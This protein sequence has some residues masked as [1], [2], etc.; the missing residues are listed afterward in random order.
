MSEFHNQAASTST[1]TLD[2][3]K[4]VKYSL[5]MV[6]G[7]DD[8]EQEFAYVSNL[9]Q[10]LARETIGYGTVCGLKVSI[11]MDERGPRVAVEPGVALTPRGQL[12]RVTPAQCAYINDW[13]DLHREEV[14]RQIGSPLASQL[15]L[16]V[17]LCY[18]G[19]P[20]DMVPIPGEPCRDETDATVDSRWQDD[21]ELKLSLTPPEQ[22]EEDA[23][24]YF[25]AWLS[26]IEITQEPTSF[27]SIQE[28][29]ESLRNAA[30]LIESSLGSPPDFPHGS[31]L[32]SSM[33][34]NSAEACDYLR[35]AFRLWV[36]ELRP[37][38]RGYD[39]YTV[40]EGDYLATIA[41]KFN[42]TDATL[43]ALNHVDESMLEA[44]M[45][46]KIPMLYCDGMPP[47]EECLLLAELDVPLLNGQ[48]DDMTNENIHEERRPYLVHLRMLQEWLL[49]GTRSMGS[50]ISP[51]DFVIPEKTFG[52]NESPG[53]LTD[54]YALAD[55]TH[56]T[57]ALPAI[58]VPPGPADTV[59]IE[60]Q[61]SQLP[62][63]GS[64]MEYS[65][66]DHSHGTPTLP[67]IPLPP[68]PADTVVTETQFSLLPNAGIAIEYSRADHTHGT[69]AS[70]G[71]PVTGDFVEHLGG[72]PQYFIIAAGVVRYK[73]PAHMP[74][75]NGL[76]VVGIPE[77]GEV[78]VTFDDYEPPKIDQDQYIVKVLPVYNI[79]IQNESKGMFALH[80][81]R[82][83]DVGFYLRCTDL[84]GN[85]T[86]QETLSRMEFMIEVSRYFA[87]VMQPRVVIE[88][89]AANRPPIDLNT[90][91]VA[92]LR[93]LPRIGPELAR[94]IV[95]TRKKTR[96]GFKSLDDLL[97]VEGIGED[98]LQVLE[99]FVT[100]SS[101]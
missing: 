28:F 45:V 70:Q 61:F 53:A 29:L 55:H 58:P 101:Q 99:P 34:I 87:R 71:A 38:W 40:K 64:A 36:T 32:E 56:G 94:R 15:R 100:V 5:G 37:R 43:A 26:Q 35:A 88:R 44:G 46:L 4:H 27:A 1:T 59:E 42:T 85:P 93:T 2:P 31:P 23:V 67:D 14:T 7:A 96:G 13:L 24:R 21:F 86:D 22:L 30:P 19:C 11:E 6:L 63:A 50:N 18:R 97:K 16:Y 10:W 77:P 91:S 17:I 98:L 82:F 48:A 62:N 78:I 74:V 60:T 41:A 75:Y 51:A 65:R 12:V 80:F 49:C 20:T 79:E 68:Q 47:D 69:P 83:S 66:A 57:P 9:P 52:L 72:L 8:L 92:E 33:H 54:Q 73:P 95:A 3:N 84:F 39:H 76:K 90:A 25:V 89:R 81:L